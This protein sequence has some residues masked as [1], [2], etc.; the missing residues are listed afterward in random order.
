MAGSQP[1]DSGDPSSIQPLRQVKD[2]VIGR[3]QGSRSNNSGGF[4]PVSP[5]AAVKVAIRLRH[6]TRDGSGAEQFWSLCLSSPAGLARQDR[7]GL[8]CQPLATGALALLGGSAP[9]IVSFADDEH[10][11]HRAALY[12]D[13]ERSAGPPSSGPEDAAASSLV[14]RCPPRRAERGRRKLNFHRTQST[15]AASAPTP[16]APSQAEG[17]RRPRAEPRL[18]WV[19]KKNRK[20]LLGNILDQSCQPEA[21]STVAPRTTT[22]VLAEISYGRPTLLRNLDETIPT[23]GRDRSDRAA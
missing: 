7:S 4:A 23:G 11:P 13:E 21:R 5:A 2:T 9:L 6:L 14:A 17:Q 10:P 19:K 20:L 8:H 12:N 3:L 18:S 15:K 22:T 1:S 16:G